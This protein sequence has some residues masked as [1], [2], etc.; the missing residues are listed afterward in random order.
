M[1]RKIAMKNWSYNE[2]SIPKLGFG[3]YELKNFSA[4]E[5]VKKA[6]ELGLRHID[7]AQI[8]DNESEVGQ[9]IKESKISRDK[10]FLTTKIWF[11]SLTSQKVKK[12]FQESLNKLKTDYVDL[13]LIHWPNS[14][15][16]LE[17]TLQAFMSLQKENKIRHIGVSNFT[18]DLLQQA[19]KICPQIITNQVEYHVL[20]NQ[21]KMLNFIEN[22]NMFLTAYSPLVRGKILQIQQLIE[23]GKKYKKSPCQIALRWLIEQKNVVVIFKSSHKTYIEENCNIFDFE[24]EDKDKALLFRLNKNKQ[25]VID[26]PFAPEW[27]D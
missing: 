14:N 20:I 21:N 3:T 17:E 8:Y 2:F 12:S 11:D 13:L 18:C 10:I 27:D 9:G 15:I 16:P 5:T 24:L 7:T 23:L 19:L 1:L 22:K 6:L 4:V 25:R 26:P